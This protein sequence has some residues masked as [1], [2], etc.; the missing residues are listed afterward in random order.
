[1][2]PRVTQE[3]MTQIAFV[4]VVTREAVFKDRAGVYGPAKNYE[5][6]YGVDVTFETKMREDRQQAFVTLGLKL[7]AAPQATD[8]FDLISVVVE[9]EFATSPASSQLTRRQSRLPSCTKRVGPRASNNPSAAIVNT[10]VAA[11]G[12]CVEAIEPLMLITAK[13]LPPAS[14]D[15]DGSIVARTLGLSARNVVPSASS[16]LV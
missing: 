11:S 10:A 8:I 16:K 14:D 3:N 15:P 4:G 6:G 5:L 13:S 1:M 12:T 9:G 7:T 2:S